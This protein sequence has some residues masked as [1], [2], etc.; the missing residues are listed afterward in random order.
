[1][2]HC[3][4]QVQTDTTSVRPGDLIKT[5]KLLESLALGIPIVTDT[6][7]LESAKA[8]HFL[9]LNDYKPKVSEQEKEWK[10]ELDKIWGEPQSTFESYAFYFTAELQKSYGNCEE[11]KQVCKAA[12]AK[13]ATKKTWKER[14]VILIASD[15]KDQEVENFG[16]EGATCYSKDLIVYSILRGEVDLDSNEFMIMGSADENTTTANTPKTQK[17]PSRRSH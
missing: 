4:T 16:R 15:E 6:W 1:M 8:G 2:G 7:L 12:G 10:F 13:L 3:S 9:A 14:N 5:M 17:K 11:L